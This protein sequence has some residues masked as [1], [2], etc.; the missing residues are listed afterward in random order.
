MK[1]YFNCSQT[2]ALILFVITIS[3]CSPTITM[4]NTSCAGYKRPEFVRNDIKNKGIGIMPVLGGDEKEQYRRP[5]G[6]A[7]FA[8]FQYTFGNQVKS[9]RDVI[10]VLN[11]YNI[12]EDYSRAIN[13]YTISGIIPK[14]LVQNL[15]HALE[16]DYL[17]Y[18]RLLTSRE[19]AQ[20][21]TG[22]YSYT[23]VNIDELYV[24]TQVW[25]VNLGDVVWEGKGGVAKLSGDQSDIITETATGL[26]NVVGKEQNQGPCQ[27]TS[28][29][30]NAIQSAAINTYLSVGGI[31]F[32]LILLLLGG[33]GM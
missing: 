4:V 28:E 9:T 3:A 21:Y 15:G 23:T 16:V 22:S 12:S 11:D 7:I 1:N 10:Q 24:Q 18:T 2:A 8:E 6:D 26:A 29:L 25:D 19:Y 27:E 17:L 14:E 13:N 31:S 30:I 5:M 33:M 20:I 32:V